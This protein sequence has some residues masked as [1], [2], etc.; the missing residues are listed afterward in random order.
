MVD[1][2][3]HSLPRSNNTCFAPGLC[4]IG[5]RG[6]ADGTGKLSPIIW[7]SGIK[8]N[9]PLSLFLLTVLSFVDRFLYK[10]EK[11]QGHLLRNLPS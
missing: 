2:R 7:D 4:T 5:S 8:P 1:T 3:P 6:G 10:Q 9:I 11:T